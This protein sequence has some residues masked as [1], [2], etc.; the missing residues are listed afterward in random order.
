MR[1]TLRTEYAIQ[2]LLHLAALPAGERDTISEISLQWSIPEA[3][4]RR[5]IPRLTKLGF[6]TSIV[7]GSGGIALR[8]PA[9]SITLL[10]VIESVEGPGYFNRCMIGHKPC[11]L[12]DVCVAHSLWSDARQKLREILS[13]K[14]LAELSEL[15]RRQHENSISTMPQTGRIE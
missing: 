3:Y 2:T 4:L 11:N 9:A 6:V 10:D 13:R 5:L 8:K 14:S 7:G 12:E 1:L 15:A